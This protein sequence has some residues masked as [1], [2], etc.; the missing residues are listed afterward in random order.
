MC[1]LSNHLLPSANQPCRLEETKAGA[2]AALREGSLGS[3]GWCWRHRHGVCHVGGMLPDQGSAASGQPGRGRLY[4]HPTACRASSPPGKPFQGVVWVLPFG[5]LSSVVCLSPGFPTVPS[6]KQHL[7]AEA[8]AGQQT[9][10]PGASR[11]R[12]LTSIGGAE[13][14]PQ[15]LA[16]PQA[17]R[18]QRHGSPARHVRRVVN[19]ARPP[20]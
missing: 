11:L 18:R 4:L 17:Q 5:R 3:L 14:A 16:F 2:G 12:R 20:A 13:R 6:D 19:A 7:L 10:S 8:E 15:S 9:K 1:S